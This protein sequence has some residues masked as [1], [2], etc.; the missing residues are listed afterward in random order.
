ME[1][2]F[3]IN[4]LRQEYESGKGPRSSIRLVRPII[5]AG[6]LLPAQSSPKQVL[7]TGFV[8]SIRMVQIMGVWV[9]TSTRPLSHSWGPVEPVLPLPFFADPVRVRLD[10]IEE[11]RHVRKAS[12]SDSHSEVRLRSGDNRPAECRREVATCLTDWP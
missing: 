8:I 12:L 4:C 3:R 9:F 11:S 1:H 7:P 10:R 5:T 2:A 6:E